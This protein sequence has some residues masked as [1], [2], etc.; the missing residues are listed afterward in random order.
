[1]PSAAD[2][3]RGS[4]RTFAAA[5]TTD[6]MFIGHFGAGLGLKRAAP[7]LSLG[8]LF[9]AAQFLDLLWPTL[10]LAGVEQVE[11]VAGPERPPL[12]F[13]HYPFSHSLAL[14]LVWAA[15]IGGA[16]Y[17]F[18]RQRTA[19][20]ICGIAVLSHWILDLIVH[21]PDLPLT[22]GAAHHVGL[23]L[24]SSVVG[25]LLVELA[26]FAGGCWLYLKATEARDRIGRFGFWGLVAFLLLIQ[27]GNVM[28][29]PPPSVAAVAW[30]GQAQWLLVLAGYWIDA[31]RRTR[32]SP[33]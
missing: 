26:I 28:G 16:H 27:A 18:R 32:V 2:A 8:T 4:G 19:A 20:L 13:T 6:P 30:V 5:E 29:G 1:M 24:W 31:H 22:P 33:A 3:V 11:I 21:H 14:T 9:F 15:A 12:R 7:G 23:G 10:L 25:S 17:A